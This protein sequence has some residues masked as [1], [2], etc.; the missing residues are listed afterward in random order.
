[1]QSVVVMSWVYNITYA[2]CCCDELC[3]L[4]LA[5]LPVQV[6]YPQ[7]LTL[8]VLCSAWCHLYTTDRLKEDKKKYVLLT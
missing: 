3:V 8:H 7:L 6:D 5:L 4:L 2:E 1:M